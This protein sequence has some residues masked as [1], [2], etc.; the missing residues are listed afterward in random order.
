MISFSAGHT[1]CKKDHSSTLSTLNSQNA[2]GKRTRSIKCTTVPC[3]TLISC[4]S[5]R[6]IFCGWPSL[7]MLTTN[8]PRSFKPTDRLFTMSSHNNSPE[9][10]STTYNRKQRHKWD[11]QGRKLDAPPTSFHITHRGHCY[12]NRTNL[13]FGTVLLLYVC[14]NTIHRILYL[15]WNRDPMVQTMWCHENILLPTSPFF[16]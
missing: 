15:D 3:L 11:H 12:I 7:L 2:G 6:H 16:V 1:A 9:S 5:I 13:S 4:L 8:S 14:P 10:K